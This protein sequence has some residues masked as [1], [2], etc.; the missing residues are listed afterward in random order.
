MDFTAPDVIPDGVYDAKL[1]SIEQR[2][3]GENSTTQKPYLRWTFAVFTEDEPDGVELVKNTSKSFG[4]KSN[5]RK[6]VQSLLGKPIQ[7]KET[8]KMSD[9][10]PLDCQVAVEIDHESGYNRITN[11]MGA[12]KGKGKK[13]D[14][15]TL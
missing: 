7:P 11:V 1:L 6:Y 9:H 10:V 5:A 15:E 12:K 14:G 3:P 4:Q 13:T 8:I 2:E